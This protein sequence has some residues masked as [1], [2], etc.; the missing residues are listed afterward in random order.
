LKKLNIHKYGKCYQCKVFIDCFV[1]SIL[2]NF[3][4]LSC[5]EKMNDFYYQTKTFFLDRHF[6]KGSSGWLQ[7]VTE[8][9]LHSKKQQVRQFFTLK[10]EKKNI[11]VLS[12]LTCT[13]YYFG[14]NDIKEKSFLCLM[15]MFDES[16][17][18]NFTMT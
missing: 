7:L 3:F 17:L 6:K 10:R 2:L 11:G 18:N 16:S 14:H 15:F 4:T 5:N 12:I 9:C 13:H 8:G 1:V